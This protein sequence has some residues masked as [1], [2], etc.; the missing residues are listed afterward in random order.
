MD[1][2][3]HRVGGGRAAPGPRICFDD[4]IGGGVGAGCEPRARLGL[5]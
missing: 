4:G 3:C 2:R 1:I 5:G